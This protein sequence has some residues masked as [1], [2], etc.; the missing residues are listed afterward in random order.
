MSPQGH[1]TSVVRLGSGF[2]EG[3]V[4]VDTDLCPL[5]CDSNMWHHSV[6]M[7]QQITHPERCSQIYINSGLQ[8]VRFQMR[9]LMSP[10]PGES[11][12][13]RSTKGNVKRNAG[14]HSFGFYGAFNLAWKADF[15]ATNDVTLKLTMFYVWKMKWRPCWNQNSGLLKFLQLSHVKFCLNGAFWWHSPPW[16]QKIPF[17][18]GMHLYATL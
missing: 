14:W 1:I 9:T 11:T 15:G 8:W 17:H 18:N 3:L 16:A 12:L 4:W 5:R 2:I 7:P 6:Y 10:L 13:E